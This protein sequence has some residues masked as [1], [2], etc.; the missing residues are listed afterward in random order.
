LKLVILGDGEMREKLIDLSKDLGLR[1]YSVWSG[2]KIDDHYDTYFLGFQKN[3][4]KF[5]RS[6]KLFVMTSLLEGFGNTIVESMA[7]GTPVMST[8][9]RFGP[10][11]IISPKLNKERSMEEPNDD[12]Y[13]VLM[14][15]FANTFVNAD[16]PLDDREHLWLDTL[17]DLLDNDKK[18]A[19]YSELGLERAEDFCL[20]SIMAEW[21]K[22]IDAVIYE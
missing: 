17:Q 8:R 12:G 5:I 6:S 10:S 18:L 13:G 19:E 9:C 21:K 14:P 11:E 16:E 3:P 4:F 15:V 22:L 20:E 2:K 7:C 1:T